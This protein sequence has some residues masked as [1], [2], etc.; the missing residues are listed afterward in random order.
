MDQKRVG[1]FILEER[2][3]KNLTQQ[4]L[5]DLLGVSEKTIANWEHARCMPDH[6]MMKS[7]CDQFDINLDE[8]YNGKR[9]EKINELNTTNKEYNL[10]LIIDE[11]TIMEESIFLYEKIRDRRIELGMSQYELSKKV[12]T[13]K[14]HIYK[15]EKGLLIPN[16]N[17]LY[18]IS[19]VLNISID[20][21]I[22][23]KK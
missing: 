15:I 18:L 11:N 7:I 2:K 23:F 12:N 8:L 14:Y 6:S 21:L 4:E 17:T 3:R 5:G 13:T 19:S 22:Y 16:I 9:Q 20:D 1:Q 10:N